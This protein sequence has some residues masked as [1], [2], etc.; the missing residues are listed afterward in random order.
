MISLAEE[1]TATVV[2]K[3]H[4]NSIEC[5]AFNPKKDESLITGSHDHTLKTWDVVK[6]TC[7]STLEAHT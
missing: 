4:T 2:L 1:L 3:G 5:C 6:G 7:V